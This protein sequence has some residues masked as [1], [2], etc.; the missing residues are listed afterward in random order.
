MTYDL[1]RASELAAWRVVGGDDR[2]HHFLRPIHDLL[3]GKQSNFVLDRVEVNQ[4]REIL[5]LVGQRIREQSG[6]FI[7]EI[8]IKSLELS[9]VG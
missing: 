6:R 9:S 1:F 7:D 4:F 5:H 3:R 8:G 2:L